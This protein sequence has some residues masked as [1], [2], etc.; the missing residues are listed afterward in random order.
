M[1]IRHEQTKPFQQ[2]TNYVS[3]PYKPVYQIKQKKRSFRKV[4]TTYIFHG[5]IGDIIIG[6]FHKEINHKTTL[7]IIDCF[8]Q[9]MVK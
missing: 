5:N 6:D 4:F 2:S 3:C 1:L 8:Q 9:Q 7:K